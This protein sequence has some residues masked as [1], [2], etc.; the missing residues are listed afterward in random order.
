MIRRANLHA[1]KNGKKRVYSSKYALSSI[2]YCGE[3]S[4][5]YRRVHWSN[6]GCRS[7]VWRCVTRLEEKGSDCSSSTIKEEVLQAAVVEAIN[8]LLAT[9]DTFLAALHA[10]IATVLNEENDRTTKDI[11][12]KLDELQNELL[13][14]ANSKADYSEVADEIYRLRELKQNA[15]AENAEREGKRQRI[16]EMTYFINEQ[17]CEIEVYDEQL[18]RRLIE[19]VTVVDGR[20]IIEFKSSIEIEIEM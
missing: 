17:P 7:I 15:L 1:G 12:T 2:V 18:V 10:N 5:I 6:R 3:C 13:K 9:K 14:L 19:K 8:E 20:L 16:V 11:D 4:E